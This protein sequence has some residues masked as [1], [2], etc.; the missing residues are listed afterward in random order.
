MRTPVPLSI[1]LVVLLTVVGCAGLGKAPVSIQQS[2]AVVLESSKALETNTNQI[3]DDLKAEAKD[4]RAAAVGL[5]LKNEAARIKATAVTPEEALTAYQEA[6]A[7]AAAKN[8]EIASTIDQKTEERKLMIGYQFA[9]QRQYA[10]LVDAY[11]KAGIP[12]SSLTDLAQA[13]ADLVA[14]A[15]AAQ[16]KANAAKTPDPNTA[17]WNNILNLIKQNSSQY[18]L[19]ALTKPTVVK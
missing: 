7:K 10:L 4:G 19:N 3:I 17:Q 1:M 18:V 14:K 11:N 8:A 5:A 15:Q 9:V 12:I 2:Q 16:A 6:E 13:A